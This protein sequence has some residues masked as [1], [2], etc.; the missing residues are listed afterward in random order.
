MLGTSWAIA[1]WSIRLCI[2]SVAKKH[3]QHG[4][5]DWKPNKTEGQNIKE[6]WQHGKGNGAATKSVGNIANRML[7]RARRQATALA[8]TH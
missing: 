8:P 5:D 3:R 7:W 4:K 1:F 2:A 6:S